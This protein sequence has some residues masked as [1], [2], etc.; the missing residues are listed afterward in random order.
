MRNRLQASVLS[1][2][3][4]ADRDDLVEASRAIHDA[5][6]ESLDERVR[7]AVREAVRE[8]SSELGERV[9][10]LLSRRF[11]QEMGPRLMGILKGYDDR[12]LAAEES[13]R[14]K[15][16]ELAEE[17][18]R[19]EKER[20][21]SLSQVIGQYGQKSL[22]W[23]EKS[24]RDTKGFEERY[25]ALERGWAE[26]SLQDK[27]AAEEQASFLKCAFDAAVG[28]IQSLLSNLQVPPPVVHVAAPEVNVAAPSVSVNVPE[29]VV[30]VNVPQQ[31]APTVSVTVPEAQTVVNVSTPARRTTKHIAYDEYNRPISVVEVE[32]D[33]VGKE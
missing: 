13:Y 12:A 6:S 16:L 24:L 14:K 26:K 23:E 29:S 32:T 15:S 1:R 8:V 33:D 3:V 4:Q 9:E 17:H 27:R 2:P 7:G 11:E 18:A 25:L 20:E 28:Q 21:E 30:Q 10:G 22:E 31:A 19:R 5:L